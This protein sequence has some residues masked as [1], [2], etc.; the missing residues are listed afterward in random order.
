MS[1]VRANV[2][3][4]S[5][6]VT[7]GTV[8]QVRQFH[9]TSTFVASGAFT[10]PGLDVSITPTSNSSRILVKVS[11]CLST[12]ATTMGFI[13]TRNGTQ[14]ALSDPVGSSPRTTMITSVGNNVWQTQCGFD[15][16]DT[17]GTTSSLTYG[18]LIRSHDG[19]EIRM[20]RSGAAP[21]GANLDDCAATSAITV[22]EIAG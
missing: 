21:G 18:I 17:P 22:M 7:Y 6:G 4:N 1:I 8:L 5:L 11:C 12:N 2:W 19:R 20:N 13:I 9:R 16:L 15:F 14:I 10:S 3:Q